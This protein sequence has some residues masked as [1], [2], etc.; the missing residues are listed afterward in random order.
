M[1][2]RKSFAPATR[3]INIPMTIAFVVGS[4]LSAIA[5]T[6]EPAPPIIK[7]VTTLP[8]I[9]TVLFILLRLLFYVFSGCRNFKICPRAFLCKDS[10]LMRAQFPNDLT[11]PAW[12]IGWP[13]TDGLMF[14]F[15]PRFRARHFE[16]FRPI[17]LHN[18]LHIIETLSHQVVNFT[19]AFQNQYPCVHLIS[20]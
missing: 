12:P 15:R 8:M 7:A 16:A 11:L 2:V 14:L 5:V 10:M 18:I 17:S 13:D 19:N 1:N 4:P 20:R 3:P 9:R 6:I